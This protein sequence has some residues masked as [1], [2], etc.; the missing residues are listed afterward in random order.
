MKGGT[1]RTTGKYELPSK[2]KRQKAGGDKLHLWQLQSIS[3][4]KKRG[5]RRRAIYRCLVCDF[6][7]SATWPYTPEP[8][9]AYPCPIPWLIMR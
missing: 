8:R 9:K 3:N 7:D 5:K 2:S 6:V 1:I 4:K